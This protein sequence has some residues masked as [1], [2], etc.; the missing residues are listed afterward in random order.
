MKFDDYA[1]F[2]GEVIEKCIEGIE[3][4]AKIAVP[5]KKCLKIK[6]NIKKKIYNNYQRKRDYIR[7]NYMTKK[8]E[9]ALDRHKVASCMMY[10]ILKVN[11][12]YV[13]RMIPSLPEKILLSNQYLAFFVALNIIEMYKLDEM[14]DKGLFEKY[15]IVIPKTYHEE[16]NI[17]NTYESNFCKSLYYLSIRN[18]NSYDVFAYADILFLLEKYTDTFMELEDLTK[19]VHENIFD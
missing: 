18:I 4:Y 15:Q 8:A 13:N 3:T 1:G 11:P 7:C 14:K 2:Y 5:N 17:E 12:F 10:A 6:N 19:K 9:V 16:V